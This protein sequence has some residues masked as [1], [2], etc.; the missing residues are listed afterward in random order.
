MTPFERLLT[1][2]DAET[3][4]LARN[5]IGREQLALMIAKATLEDTTVK[6]SSVNAANVLGMPQSTVSGQ[7]DRIGFK[8][9]GGDQ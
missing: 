8:K 9:S 6:P 5:I 7:I 4:V 3:L 1:L 2:A